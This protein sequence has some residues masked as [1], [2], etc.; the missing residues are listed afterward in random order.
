MNIRSRAFRCENNARIVTK[1]PTATLFI[2]VPT[3]MASHCPGLAPREA[4]TGHCLRLICWR[5]HAC[6][7][8]HFPV[9]DVHTESR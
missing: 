8:P 5:R 1:F 9:A 4:E 6:L 7:Q 2:V 3:L